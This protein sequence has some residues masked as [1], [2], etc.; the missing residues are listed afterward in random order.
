MLASTDPSHLENCT[1]N[2]ATTMQIF[3]PV[4]WIRTFSAATNM[5]QMRHFSNK[6]FN[7][8]S[9]DEIPRWST[10]Q[11]YLWLHNVIQMPLN[12]LEHKF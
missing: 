1:G 11:N 3:N 12:Y 8:I 9:N 7:L 4:P 5:P 6:A 2:E 10:P